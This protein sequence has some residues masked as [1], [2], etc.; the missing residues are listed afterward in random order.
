MHEEPSHEEVVAWFNA[1]QADI[2]KIDEHIAPYLDRR[3]RLESRQTLLKDLLSSFE[4]ADVHDAV[5]APPEHELLSPS[6]SRPQSV[7]VGEYVRG[8]AEEILRAE[9]PMHIN[10]L[11]SRFLAKGLEIPGAGEPVNLIVH[12]RKDPGIVSPARG[13]YALRDR[14]DV[15]SLPRSRRSVKATG[16][17]QPKRRIKKRARK[18][19][20]TG[21]SK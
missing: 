7:G 9:G 13:M 6:F 19:T 16:K 3:R 15:A 1:V 21:S 4:A 20:T 14:V 8:H 12:L 17:A 2:A 18:T 5:E 11:H 10:D